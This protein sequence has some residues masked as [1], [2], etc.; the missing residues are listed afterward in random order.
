MQ[1]YAYLSVCLFVYLSVGRYA[2][3]HVCLYTC[4]WHFNVCMHVA[5][6]YIRVYVHMYTCMLACIHLCM[7]LCMYAGGMYAHGYVRMYACMHVGVRVHAYHHTEEILAAGLNSPLK[8]GRRR[9]RSRWTVSCNG[10]SKT[11]CALE[12]GGKGDLP[13]RKRDRDRCKHVQ[14]VCIYITHSGIT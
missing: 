6:V 7:Y 11:A 3:V 8:P 2:R 1:L 9:R 14:I 12:H 13:L 10:H 4:M 5:R